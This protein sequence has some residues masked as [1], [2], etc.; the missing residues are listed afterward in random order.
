MQMNGNLELITIAQQYSQ[1]PD[2]RFIVLVLNNG[3]LNFVTW[4]QRMMQGEPR[5]SVS[6]HVPEFNYAEYAQS[7]GLRGIRITHP[8]EVVGALEEALSADRPVV[9][10]A[11]TDPEIIVFT[12]EVALKYAPKLAKAIGQGDQVLG[13]HLDE[14]LRSAVEEAAHVSL[15]L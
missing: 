9:L 5:F 2:K 12:P 4:E 8:D 15:P 6:Q 1:W 3:D 7:L 10:E 14:P 13:Q 11:L